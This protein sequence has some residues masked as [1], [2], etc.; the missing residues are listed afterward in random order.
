MLSPDPSV[1]PFPNP[2][3]GWLKEE[4]MDVRAYILD[5][6]FG[7]LVEARVREA[8]LAEEDRYW[9]SL[10]QAA[11]ARDVSYR[12]LLDSINDSGEAD[13]VNP[14]AYRLVELTT[15]YVLGKGMA[16]KADQEAVQ[17]FVDAFWQGQRVEVGP[18][19]L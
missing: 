3:I 4:R 5:R 17:G 8:T 19:E 14:V 13:R 1:N 11:G 10:S 9:R 12:E 16:L 15:D 18:F 2:L 7:D 6:I